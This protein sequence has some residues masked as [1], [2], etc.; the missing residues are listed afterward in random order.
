MTQKVKK[1]NWAFVVY[2]E[3]AP[4]NWIEILIKTGLPFVVSP[5]HNLDVNPT[6]EIK[7]PHWH[8]IVAYAGPTA[9]NVVKRVTDSL[10]SPIPQ[11]LESVKGYYRYLT[12]KDNPEKAQYDE[13]EIKAYNGFDISDFCEL[14]GSEIQK[15]K[16]D[17]VELIVE[18]C[19]IEYSELI[20]ILLALSKAGEANAFEKLKVASENT[21]FFDTYIRSK[22]NHEQVQ[23]REEIRARRKSE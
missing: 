18:N 16:N 19:I 8:V 11:P 5:L 21:V 13:K 12:H 10:N 15:I 7:K 4:E 14:T 9:F 2:P 3:S 23:M 20:N 6:G 22:R 1:R 17:V